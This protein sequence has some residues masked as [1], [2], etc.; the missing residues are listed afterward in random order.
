MQLRRKRA[1][2]VNRTSKRKHSAWLEDGLLLRESEI[3]GVIVN[4][5]MDFGQPIG[6]AWQPHRG[7]PHSRLGASEAGHAL[8]NEAIAREI[9]ATAEFASLIE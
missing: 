8:S 4:G 5:R 7:F 6:W 3:P 1:A 2:M 9:I